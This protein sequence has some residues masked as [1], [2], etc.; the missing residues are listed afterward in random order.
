MMNHN[1]TYIYHL[2]RMFVDDYIGKI[3]VNIDVIFLQTRLLYFTD[4]YNYVP[5]APIMCKRL[6]NKMHATASPSSPE[7]RNFRLHI[8]IKVSI[9]HLNINFYRQVFVIYIFL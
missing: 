4:M 3:D 2:T 7:A 9:Q 1:A 6:I 5:S 8:E